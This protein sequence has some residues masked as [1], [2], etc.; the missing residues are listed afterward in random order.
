MVSR[1]AFL[2]MSLPKRAGDRTNL[3]SGR[4]VVRDGQLVEGAAED[5]QGRRAADGTMDMECAVRKHKQLLKRQY[6]GSN[7]GSGTQ[8]HGRGGF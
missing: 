3:G 1:I 6:F 2:R 8:T 5:Y 7:P 4:F